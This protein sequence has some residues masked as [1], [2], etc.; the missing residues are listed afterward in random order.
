MSS[1][2]FLM[3]INDLLVEFE[4]YEEEQCCNIGV[5]AKLAQKER[6]LCLCIKIILERDIE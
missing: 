3:P 1:L 4:D 5:F 6:S 2:F